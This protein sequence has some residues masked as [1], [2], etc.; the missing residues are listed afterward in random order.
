[1]TTGARDPLSVRLS[2]CLVAGLVLAGCGGLALLALI[3]CNM[4]Y[5]MPAQWWCFVLTPLT[6]LGLHFPNC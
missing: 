6:W 1:M 4:L 2:G 5:L 3:S